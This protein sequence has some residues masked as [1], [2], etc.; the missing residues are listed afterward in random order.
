MKEFDKVIEI[1]DRI[2]LADSFERSSLDDYINI[3]MKKDKK[4]NEL[5]IFD[6][7]GDEIGRTTNKVVSSGKV[8]TIENLFRIY[9]I[10]DK[11]NIQYDKPDNRTNP[12]WISTF[13]IG[14]GGASLSEG[15]NP[16]I[17]DP[18]AT[19]LSTPMVFRTDTNLPVNTYWDGVKK[20]NFS[21][22]Y[23]NW[24]KSADDIYALLIC[25][26]DY[27]DCLGKS[28]N[29][30]GLYMCNHILDSNDQIIGKEKFS[31]YAKANLNAI[32]KSPYLDKSAYRIA[33]K[34]YI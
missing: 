31:L 12:R 2:K 15:N 5:V 29:E 1:D 32:N 3:E 34:V 6:E 17:V 28:I 30:L 22:I 25:E 18:N 10:S 23:L 4:D 19:E 13:G 20:K 33:Y 21:A 14:S 16:Y 7:N 27:N 24:D 11:N 9:S 8:E 26:L